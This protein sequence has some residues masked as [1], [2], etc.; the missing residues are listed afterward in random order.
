MSDPIAPHGDPDSDPDSPATTLRDPHADL[1]ADTP[2]PGHIVERAARV[3]L[4]ALDVDGVLTDG[5]LLFGDD[6][7]ERKA[8]HVRDGHGLK[9]LR[10]CG[11][12]VA[13]ISARASRLVGAR[14]LELGVEHVYLGETEKLTASTPC[15]SA[16][17]SPMRTPPTSVMICSIYH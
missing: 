12:D 9:M 10:Q 8:F 11:I 17:R 2:W 3:R 4:L 6:G 16:S 13:V 1:R 14:M 5:R 7:V 15:W